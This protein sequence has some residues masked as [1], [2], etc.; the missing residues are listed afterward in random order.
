MKKVLMIMMVFTVL[1][2]CKTEKKSE[3]EITPEDKT[4]VAE[5]GKTI[6]QSDGLIA[7][8]GEFIYYADAAVLKTP[9]QMYGIVINE[10]MHEL[11]KQAQQYKKEDTDMV[12]VTIRGRLFKK[13][14]EAEGW[15]NIIEIKEIL[16][17]SEPTPETNDVIKLGSN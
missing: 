11:D 3:V 15:D 8:Q 14:P 13:E 5:E 17:V 2:S 6:K 4:I 16:K 1:M 7:I 10:K 12:P 9:T